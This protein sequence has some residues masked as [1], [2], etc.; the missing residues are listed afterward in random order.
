MAK[1]T[2]WA[3]G[4]GL[5]SSITTLYDAFLI[6]DV[7]NRNI[8][9]IDAPPLFET[10]IVTTDGLPVEACG[11]IN[12]Q[13][14]RSIDDVKETDCIIIS[15]YL[16][17]ENPMPG[18]LDVLSEWIKEHRSRGAVIATVCTG[19]FILAEMGFL[20]GKTAT[21]NWQFA[22]MFKRRYPKVD[23]KPEFMLTED[24]GVICTGASTAAYNLG[25]YLIKKFSSQKLARLC[26]KALL[27]DPNRISQSPYVVS[28]SVKSHG[29]SQ[30]LRAQQLIEENYSEIE[31]VDEIAREVGISS[32]HF[33][34]RFMKATGDLPLK[35]LQRIRIEAAKEK[36]ETTRESV[37]D[38][39][40]M[41]GYQDVSSF[42]RLFK[43]YTNL[44]PKA[45]RD[46]FFT[47]GTGM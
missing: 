21:T 4:G 13:P 5:F 27:V 43:R 12:I 18:N 24:D 37:N 3:G 25:M 40:W 35:Y 45:Y 20:D 11:G 16:P 28:T 26:S 19:A 8:A 6:A 10:E 22:R 30:I 34:R 38:I 39:T 31:N 17:G 47:A 46:K 9:K 41:V 7:C 14:H 15:P 44:S 33:K 29:D 2:F 42:C 36:L 1:I 32:R 23:L